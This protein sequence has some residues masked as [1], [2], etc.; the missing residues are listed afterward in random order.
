MKRLVFAGFHQPKDG[1]GYATIKIS[2]A[3]R[4]AVPHLVDILDLGEPILDETQQ[5]QTNAPTVALCTP[6]WLPLLDTGGAPLVSYTMFE[7]TRLPA[8]WVDKLNQF[9]ALV[10]VP[11]EWN[12]TIFE[13][14]GVTRPI[15]VVKWGID[16]T[17]YWPLER[18]HKQQPYTFLWS[19]TPDRRKGWDVAY[20][21]FLQAFG[22]RD[23]VHLMLHFRHLPD[24]L[25]G[26]ADANVELRSGL[27]D[28]PELRT[29]LAGA[30]CFVF[31]S[32]GEGWGLPP[33]EAAATGLPV[34]ATEHGGL[35]E[36]INEWGIPLK[37]AGMSPAE[38]GYPEWGNIGYWIEPDMAHLV[39]LLRWCVD[40]PD[41]ARRI[42]RVA[43]EFLAKHTPW[44][45][46]ALDLVGVLYATEVYRAAHCAPLSNAVRVE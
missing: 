4:E 6:D 24:G 34:I 33:R 30:D 46:T 22:D 28:R 21:A 10:L 29:L 35:A 9:A 18:I 13:A 42:G 39:E 1:Y 14:N 26:T 7:A 17:D 31:P 19:G 5:W 38:Y 15:R 41:E 37:T 8:G 32:R 16:S 44:K 45:R 27:L 36:E 20:R 40:E 11:C 23:D 12:K 2:E 3:L 43:A 25:Q